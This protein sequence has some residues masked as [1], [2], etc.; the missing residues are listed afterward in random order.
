MH[1]PLPLLCP[2]STAT[3]LGESASFL[4]FKTPG[5]QSRPTLLIPLIDASHENVFFPAAP[6][7]ATGTWIRAAR[8]INTPFL[9]QV[10]IF[11]NLDE[12][13]QQKIVHEM[14][15]RPVKAGEIIIREGDSGASP[16]PP[17]GNTRGPC[18]TLAFLPS[19]LTGLGATELYVVK[20]GTFE[21]LERRRGQNFR[22][23]SKGPGG[24]HVHLFPRAPSTA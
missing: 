18:P 5:S 12:S 13:V 4:L 6:F 2:T 22:V 21:V 15:E 16:A 9:F 11:S 8:K 20:S 14:Y 19:S 17:L 3:P 1:R 10:M 23:N 7:R 24:C